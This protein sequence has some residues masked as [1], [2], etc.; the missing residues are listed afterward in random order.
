MEAP[1]VSTATLPICAI[2]VLVRSFG[3]VNRDVRTF[4]ASADAVGAPPFLT[5]A[6]GF[7]FVLLM[8]VPGATQGRLSVFADM[9]L[10]YALMENR[11][12]AVSVCSRG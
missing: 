10:L 4:I 7:P 2:L 9:R 8:T 12:K 11:V 5:A 6:A 3:K 1:R